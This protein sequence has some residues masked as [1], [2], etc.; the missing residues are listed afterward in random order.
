MEYR[1]LLALLAAVS[2]PSCMIHSEAPANPWRLWQWGN[3]S[4][5]RSMCK[6]DHKLASQN[7]IAKEWNFSEFSISFALSLST[8]KFIKIACSSLLS[9]SKLKS[10]PRYLKEEPISSAGI[11]ESSIVRLG[12]YCLYTPSCFAF[13]LIFFFFKRKF[14]DDIQQIATKMVSTCN[15]TKQAYLYTI[16]RTIEN[17]NKQESNNLNSNSHHVECSEMKV[18]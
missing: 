10:L 14:L 16:K 6:E 18:L 13:R 9:I 1:S 12:R 3:P 5:V 4:S 15:L 11:V 8:P 7:W 17:L 2:I